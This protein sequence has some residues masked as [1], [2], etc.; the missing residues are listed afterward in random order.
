VA[1]STGHVVD[2]TSRAF[3]DTEAHSAMSLS[4]VSKA[5][6]TSTDD[7]GFEEKPIAEGAADTEIS[8][9]SSLPY[10]PLFEQLRENQERDEEERLE[11]QKAAMSGTLTLDDEDC[12]HLQNIQNQQLS[13]QQKRVKET[14]MEVAAFRS[15]QANRLITAQHNAAE[16]LLE[17]DSGNKNISS[18]QPQNKPASSTM[19][20]VSKQVKPPV[21]IRRRPRQNGNEGIAPITHDIPAKDLVHN[22]AI[23]HLKGEEPCP[24]S[25]KHRSEDSSAN[26]PISTRHITIGGI[27]NL[28]AG[29]DSDEDE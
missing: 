17:T 16:I 1:F 2:D 28:L 20:A 27:S 15:A 25:K 10:R 11:S 7:G 23:Q 3:A 19:A 5:V 24:A 4:F 26:T 22:E 21:V 13:L 8:S 12:A 6:Q 14:N 18:H 29:Y 9:S